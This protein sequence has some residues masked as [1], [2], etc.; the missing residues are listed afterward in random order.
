MID[1]VEDAVR[2]L[3]A[4]ISREADIRVVKEDAPDV[5]VASGQMV[6]VVVDLI[7]NAVKATRP[8][9]RGTVTIAVGPGVPGLARLDV[10][11]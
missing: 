4:A 1:V 11:D 2:S 9:D 7:G 10:I 5:I 3:P 6:Q 8:G